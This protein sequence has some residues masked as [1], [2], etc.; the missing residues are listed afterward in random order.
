MS[1]ECDP[2]G[3]MIRYTMEWS[4]GSSNCVVNYKI[5]PFVYWYSGQIDFN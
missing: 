2:A 3:Y 1:D 5:R 4:N